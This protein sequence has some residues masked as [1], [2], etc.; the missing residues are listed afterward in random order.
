[1]LSSDG[2]HSRV[3]R[4]LQAGRSV[5]LRLVV[6]HG[7]LGHRAHVA[8]LRGAGIG[9]VG[10]QNGGSGSD[11]GADGVVHGLTLRLVDGVLQGG[12]LG[13]DGG[14]GVGQGH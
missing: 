12:A 9:V 10:R 3:A 2:A 11:D 6:T 5:H 13:R 7:R 14:L 4:S 8:L 1:M